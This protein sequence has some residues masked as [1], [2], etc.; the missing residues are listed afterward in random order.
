MILIKL[1]AFFTG[2]HR[3]ILTDKYIAS[4]RIDQ[5]FHLLD[6]GIKT[7]NDG[8]IVLIGRDCVVHTA[9]GSDLLNDQE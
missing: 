8:I 9:F 6:V 3:C 2:N 5:H 1:L 7:L 4:N